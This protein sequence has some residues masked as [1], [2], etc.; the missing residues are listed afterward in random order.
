M[1]NPV[2]TYSMRFDLS[3]QNFKKSLVDIFSPQIE[4]RKRCGF[5]LA[6]ETKLWAI[7][8]FLGRLL[9]NPCTVFSQSLWVNSFR[10][11]IRGERA[12]KISHGPRD[13]KRFGREEKWDLGTRQGR[14]QVTREIDEIEN[15][16]YAKFGGKTKSNM[17][18]LGLWKA[19]SLFAFRPLAVSCKIIF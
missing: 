5:S 3:F 8:C 7:F 18:F 2:L 9:P 13:P 1:N 14:L 17:V 10:W 16:S 6:V 12:G 19:T 4:R 15:N 11:R